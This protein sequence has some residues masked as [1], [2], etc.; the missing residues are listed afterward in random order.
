MYVGVGVAHLDGQLFHYRAAADVF[1]GVSDIDLHIAGQLINQ[2]ISFVPQFQ[3]VVTV[4][5]CFADALTEILNIAQNRIDSSYIVIER[6]NRVWRTS[7][8]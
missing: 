8:N 3:R 5:V 2:N 7:S 6:C 4:N 1:L